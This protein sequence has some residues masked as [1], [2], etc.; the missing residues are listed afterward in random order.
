PRRRPGTG[1]FVRVMLAEQTAI[2][3]LDLLWIGIGPNAKQAQ[4]LFVGTTGMARR[5]LTLT[6]RLIQRCY[7]CRVPT[8]P[9]SPEHDQLMLA[10]IDG[11]L[12]SRH[13]PA[14]LKNR[15]GLLM[16]AA[17]PL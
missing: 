1:L 13:P 2:S 7:R 17:K 12:R 9:A 3:T 11:A 5:R 10:R 15:L 4:R 16:P 6:A 8:H 14:G